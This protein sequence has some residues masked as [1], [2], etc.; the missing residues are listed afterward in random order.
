MTRSTR[1]RKA[2]ARLADR[3]IGGTRDWLCQADGQLTR[4]EK[5]LD[6]LLFE[7]QIQAQIKEM[8]SQ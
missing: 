3:F 1:P 6:T 4:M 8:S 5:K 7:A 2:P